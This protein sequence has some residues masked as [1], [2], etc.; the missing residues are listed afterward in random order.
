MD[1]SLWNPTRTKPRPPPLWMVTNGDVTVGPVSTTTVVQG[2]LEGRVWNG[3]YVRDTRS[4]SWRAVHTL[5]EV[6]A[7]EDKL[8]RRAPREKSTSAIEA[9]LCLAETTKEAMQ[10][11]LELARKRVRADAGIAHAFDHPFKAPVTRAAQGSLTRAEIDERLTDADPLVRIA[12]ARCIAMGDPKIIPEMRM[13][14][15][16]IGGGAERL[17]G[18]A[19]VPVAGVGGVLGMLELGRADHPFRTT[20]AVVLREVSRKIAASLERI[21]CR[22]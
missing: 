10:L 14:A 20:D 4:P 19:M 7:L 18:I 5:R 6:R 22:G 17:T 12:R 8:Y 11:G 9:L 15:I 1:L 21:S 16:R 2:V 3:F 13:S